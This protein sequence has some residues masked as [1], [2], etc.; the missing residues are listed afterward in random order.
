MG[1]P[2]TFLDKYNPN[3][4]IIIGLDRYVADNP[5]FGHRFTVNG[6]ETYA[7]ILIKRRM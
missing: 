5:R 4:F 3:Q 6:K 1:V 7:R 2:I